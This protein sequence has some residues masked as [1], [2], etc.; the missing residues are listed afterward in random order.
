MTIR[1]RNRALS[2]AVHDMAAECGRRRSIR[3]VL[4]VGSP[5]GEQLTVPHERWYDAGLRADLVERALSAVDVA[6]PLVWIARL[7]GCH[8]TD[9]DHAWCRA[10][11]AASARHGHKPHFYVVTRRA[12]L[13]PRTGDCR[14][15]QRV[16][17][18]TARTSSP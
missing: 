6:E 16:R 3:P 17:S 18:S 7:G 1:E 15:W 4:H 10:T 13:D 2:R 14:T 12:W 9:D 5:Y 11:L 8:A